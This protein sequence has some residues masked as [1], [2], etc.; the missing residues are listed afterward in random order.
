M[1]SDRIMTE[2]DRA[3][4]EANVLT[5]VAILQSDVATLIDWAGESEEAAARLLH[6]VQV[7]TRVANVALVVSAVTFACLLLVVMFR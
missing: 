3:K 6:L 5:S 4:R 7:T 1:G 2:E